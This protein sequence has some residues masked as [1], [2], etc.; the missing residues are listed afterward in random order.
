MCAAFRL[1]EVTEEQC[2]ECKYPVSGSVPFRP[3]QI[4]AVTDPSPEHF[5][6]DHMNTDRY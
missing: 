2:N 3:E 4:S 6:P 5:Q 1:L